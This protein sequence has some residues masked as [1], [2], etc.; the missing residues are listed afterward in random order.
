MLHSEPVLSSLAALLAS[1]VKGSHCLCLPSAGTIG[2][3][4]H[5]QLFYVGFGD[6]IQDFMFIQQAPYRLEPS[7]QLHALPFDIIVYY[8]AIYKVHM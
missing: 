5:T 4:Y 7:L 8:A 2:T 6:Q 1:K 3:C